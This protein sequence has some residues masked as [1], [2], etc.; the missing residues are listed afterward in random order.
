MLTVNP[1]TPPPVSRYIFSVAAHQSTPNDDALESVDTPSGIE[2]DQSP[3]KPSPAAKYNKGASQ[4]LNA[5]RAKRLADLRKE[6][7]R[8]LI[9]R[10]T[11]RL[12]R[13]AHPERDHIVIR[14]EFIY[15]SSPRP[16]QDSES[17]EDVATRPPLTRVLNGKNQHAIALYLTQLFVRQMSDAHAAAKNP[18]PPPE[19]RR[20]HTVYNVDDAPS[21][22]SLIA[23]SSANRRNQRKTYSRALAALSKWE[24]V[25][26]GADRHRYTNYTLN[27]E[28]G[29]GRPYDPP[30]G[31]PEIPKHLCLPTQFFTRGWHLILTPKELAALLAICHYAD[32]K[33]PRTPDG[34]PRQ[35]YLAESVRRDHLGLSD[36]A[37]ETIHYLEEFS[38]IDIDDPV[39]GRRRGRV[40]PEKT[41]GK[42]PEP[43][44]LD[45]KILGGFPSSDRA[46]DLSL[47][48]RPAIDVA[49]ERL[50]WPL[51]R[52]AMWS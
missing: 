48:D 12:S 26:L 2:V 3:K 13:L 38:F 16:P 52:Y 32:R 4:N 47:F 49:I 34:K 11:D 5:D 33:L 45:P 10:A 36:E 18:S 31:R 9:T 44:L 8:E 51:P 29:S 19:P 24:L 7:T 35:V 15:R 20:R 22:A 21:E 39:E 17:R 6:S 37:Y 25:D 43:Y 50:N 40:S 41:G 28:D 46:F 42:R 1:L 23:L 30:R 14:S 27:R